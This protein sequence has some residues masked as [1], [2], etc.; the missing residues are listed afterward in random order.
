MAD[1]KD[2]PAKELLLGCWT[3]TSPF[4][5][6]DIPPDQREWVDAT[7]CF[8]KKGRIN[9]RTMACGR[10]SSCDGWEG[11]REYRW[12]KNRFEIAIFER[13][14]DGSTYDWEW[15]A[16]SIVFPER[17]KMLMQNCSLSPDE[18]T[19]KPGRFDE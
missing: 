11:E 5:R 9:T 8:D 7:W 17:N 15:E 6:N 10:R 12:R 14:G 4:A 13:A 2:Q 3:R 19:R 1:G 18:W 16:C